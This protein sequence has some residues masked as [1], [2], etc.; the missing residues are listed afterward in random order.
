MTRTRHEGGN[1]GPPPGIFHL[2]FMQDFV[3]ELLERGL[4]PEE[5]LKSPDRR[6]GRV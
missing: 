4:R 6:R 3:V 1:A 5:A 2:I